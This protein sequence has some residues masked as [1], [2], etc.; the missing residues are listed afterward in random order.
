MEVQIPPEEYCNLETRDEE[1]VPATQFVR[2][3]EEYS[4]FT[5]RQKKMIVIA[6]SF[7]GFFSPLSS[8]IYFP[9]LNTIAED[10]RVSISRINL[11]VT[12]YQVSIV[13]L[14]LLLQYCQCLS[15]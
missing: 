7:A 6:G 11:T 3:Q 8:N 10:L 14:E 2:S 12:T 4:I 15:A 1:L 5:T 9:A 13:L